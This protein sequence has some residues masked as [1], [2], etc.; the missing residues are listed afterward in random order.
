MIEYV[1]GIDG[2]GTNA[3]LCAMDKSGL[4]LYEGSG[5][6]T[7]LCASSEEQVCGVLNAL[8]GA[9]VRR[10]GSRPYAVCIGS[11]GIVNEDTERRMKQI[12]SEAAGGLDRVIVCNDAVIA[13]K[14]NLGCDAGLSITAG[15]GTVCLAQDEHGNTL[16]VSGWGHL[17]SDEGSAYWIARK[18]LEKVCLSHDQR[19][20]PTELTNEFYRA[21]NVSGFDDLIAAIYSEYADKDRFA[22]LA[23]VADLSAN[24]GDPAAIG[25]LEEAA[26]Q[27]F[28][29]CGF[30]A[31]RLYGKEK[32]FRVVQNG[33]V[34][35]NCAVVRSE[36][37]K[38]MR[39]AYPLCC[40]EYGKRPAVLGAADCALSTMLA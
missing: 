21:L 9:C 14:A 17:C 15:T 25:V 3:R 23:R 1:I 24:E 11:A 29:I 40:T 32:P 20:E 30:A 10:L 18:A 31:D 37:E 13:L 12:L 6:S 8:I 2:G 28:S 4:I 19:I 22:S 26:R 39:A 35:K 33:G 36:F 7:N 34:L 16:R 5:G 27:L 38:R